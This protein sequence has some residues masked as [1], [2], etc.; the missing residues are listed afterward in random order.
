MEAKGEGE[1]GRERG[2]CQRGGVGVGPNW[3]EFGGVAASDPNTLTPHTFHL[4]NFS[5]RGCSAV[6]DTH[7]PGAARFHLFLL[8]PIRT[9]ASSA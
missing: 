6:C 3:F 8:E 9:T 5:V 2:G 1:V 7:L 4:S